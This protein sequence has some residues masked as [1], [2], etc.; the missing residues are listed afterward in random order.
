[1]GHDETRLFIFSK[2]YLKVS[3]CSISISSEENNSNKLGI[4]ESHNENGKNLLISQ[5]NAIQKGSYELSNIYFIRKESCCDKKRFWNC[6]VVHTETGL[7]WHS[8]TF[9]NAPVIS[10]SLCPIACF[11]KYQVITQCH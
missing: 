7:M 5:N 4:H 1:M 8:E 10:V 9:Q 11:Y 3:I 2:L 6:I